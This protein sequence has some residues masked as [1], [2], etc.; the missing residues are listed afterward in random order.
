MVLVFWLGLWT[1]RL[2]FIHLVE[3]IKKILDKYR[4]NTYYSIADVRASVAQ[5]DRALA[6]GAKGRRFESFRTHHVT[7]VWKMNTGE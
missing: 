5:L 6:S 4:L 3:K 1:K 7:L 2:R